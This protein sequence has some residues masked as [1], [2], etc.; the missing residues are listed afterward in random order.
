MTGNIREVWTGADVR[1]LVG[2]IVL[3]AGF[4]GLG[5][6]ATTN[7]AERM[8]DA[9]S[10]AAN[11][12]SDTAT[13]PVDVAV[14]GR[15]VTVTG[16]AVDQAELDQLKSVY[17]GL[18]GVRVVNVDGVD[19]LPVADP[20][21]IQITKAADG[22]LAASGVVPSYV[23]QAQLGSVAAD[24]PLAAGAPDGWT[25]AAAAGQ[26]ALGA[27]NSGQMTLSGTTLSIT[28]EANS[29]VELSDATAALADLSGDYTTDA[30]I[31]VLDDGTPLRV[32][33][34]VAD[35]AVSG[36]V[37][38]PAEL[39]GD[40]AFTAFDT[41][42]SPL[43]AADADWPDAAR[44][45]LAASGSL[46]EGDVDLTDQN[47]VVR[48]QASPEGKTEAEATLATLPESYT[49]DVQI[50]LWDD[51]EPLQFAMD[52]DGT[53]ATA[54]GKLPADFTLSGPAG[55]TV[56]PTGTTSFRPDADG[57]FTAN[58]NAGVAA[59]ASLN[60][61]SLTV[62]ETSI[63]LTGTATSPQV[64]ADLDAILANAAP[65]TEITRDFTF[66]DD[67]SPASW[68]LDYD[69][70]N[71]GSIEG[72]LP[73][74]LEVSDL[75][76]ALG[77]PEIEGETSVALA[78]DTAGPAVEILTAVSG[79][80]PEIE[81]LKLSRDGDGT[82]L[83]M[84]MAPGVDVDLVAADLSERLP[85]DAAFSIAGTENLPQQGAYRVNA[86]TGLGEVYLNGFWIPDLNF[87]TSIEGCGEQTALQMQNGGINFLSGSA[88]LDATSVRVINALA[89]IAVPCVEADLE[90]EVAGHTDASGDAGLN[91][92][93]SE[94]RAATVRAALIARGVP[95]RAI[96]SVGF[97]ASQPIADN[98]TPE[99]RAENRRTEI[100]WFERGAPRNP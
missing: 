3:V 53:T 21:E 60:D 13:L 91:Q 41:V 10:E 73:T 43:A 28:G 99:G 81:T 74:T 88:R 37:K 17:Q 45:V 22:A 6:V 89:A 85:S 11:G 80:L 16:Q 15:D 44:T 29:P 87:V 14:S 7:H 83:D 59:L 12:V 36:A 20:F 66:L 49:Q 1:K 75:S 65:G 33:L 62:T 39:D 93:L 58:A 55:T 38:L 54:D 94:D 61:G 78:D 35:S 72:R 57:A 67:G 5:Y 2:G 64:N 34:T 96:T 48:G 42:Q 76:D 86:A 23:A 52:W 51:G 56:E 19:L 98:E 40:A 25:D 97:G 70:A 50:D 82:V 100:E 18:D 9:I 90:L 68:V 84:V 30:Q 92:T 77:V 47:L 4:G 32:D 31:D 46:I 24:L 27:L 8:E 71:G 63:A 95:E 26:N 69:A 79:Y